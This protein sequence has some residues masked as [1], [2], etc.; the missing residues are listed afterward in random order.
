MADVHA[1]LYPL[2]DGHHRQ[3]R[4]VGGRIDDALGQAE[5]DGKIFQIGR[6]RHHHRMG[7]AVVGKGDGSLFGN[8]A[9]SKGRGAET[10]LGALN[11]TRGGG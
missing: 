6:R 4:E 1:Q 7:N 2:I 3:R 9:R 11:Q 10:I 8:A 5:T